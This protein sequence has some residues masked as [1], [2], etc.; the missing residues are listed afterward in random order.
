[1]LNLK[2][3]SLVAA[4]IAD[5]ANVQL[6]VQPPEPPK[7][8]GRKPGEVPRHSKTAVRRLAELGFDPLEELIKLYDKVS[9][10][11]EEMEELKLVPKILTDGSVRRFSSMAYAQ[12]VTV[13]QKLSNDLMR[14]G[15]ARVPETVIVEKEVPRPVI[16]LTAKGEVF[17][18]E[19]V[20]TTPEDDE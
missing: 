19:M 14:Y 20:Q 18:V 4:P 11:I 7:K 10:E 9:N 8:R 15:Y 2:A 13:Q 3:P 17:D 12:L 5:S 16:N 1:M 6:T